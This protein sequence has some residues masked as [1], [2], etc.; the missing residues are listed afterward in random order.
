MRDG[1]TNIVWNGNN[2]PIK[3]V[4]K[5]MKKDEHFIRLALQNN[6]LPIGFAMKNNGSTQFDYYISPKLLY[7][8]TGFIYSEGIS[9]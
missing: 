5:V 3:V 7:D 8:Y 2:V 9:A 4:A 6:L 1:I